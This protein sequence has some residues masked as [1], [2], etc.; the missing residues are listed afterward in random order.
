MTI[1]TQLDAGGSIPTWLVDKE[2]PRSLSVVQEAIDE[3]RQDEKVDAAQLR[4]KETFMR[5]RWQ[6]E[7]YSKEEVRHSEDD[8][9]QAAHHATA[10]LTPFFAP[11]A[12]PVAGTCAREGQGDH[13]GHQG[14][15]RF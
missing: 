4:E 2:V 9:I 3:F 7:V 1:V 12:R 11:S 14:H 10:V 8:L 6:D 5:E 15:L 13:R